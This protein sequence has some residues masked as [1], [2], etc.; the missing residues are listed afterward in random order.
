MTNPFQVLL[1]QR[2]RRLP[3]S[4]LI[5]TCEIQSENCSRG[6]KKMMLSSREREACGKGARREYRYWKRNIPTGEDLRRFV[7]ATHTATME[8]S[9]RSWGD[10]LLHSFVAF[11]RRHPG[12]RRKVEG[13]SLRCVR[14]WW[15]GSRPFGMG[16]FLFRIH[17]QHDSEAYCWAASF[18][19]TGRSVVAVPPSRARTRI[20]WK[21]SS[22]PF[23]RTHRQSRR[24]HG[25]PSSLIWTSSFRSP[26]QSPTLTSSFQILIRASFDL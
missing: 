6:A 18:A 19:G 16:E 24:F 3:S 17:R 10:R 1:I 15:S 9:K 25:Y 21:T 22:V 26:V 8:R 12:H 7:R 5:S 13:A 11:R 4:R 20:R 14:L 2:S 23:P